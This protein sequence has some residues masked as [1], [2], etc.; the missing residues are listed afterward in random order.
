MAFQF[1]SITITNKCSIKD[2]TSSNTKHHGQFFLE[3]GLFVS[4]VWGGSSSNQ[5]HKSVSKISQ[6]SQDF[7]KIVA[8][9]VTNFT[10]HFIRQQKDVWAT[11]IGTG[12]V[13]RIP[14]PESDI[15]S[16]WKYLNWPEFKWNLTPWT[17]QVN[18]D[19]FPFIKNA[20]ICWTIKGNCLKMKANDHRF[21][22][23]S[24]CLVSN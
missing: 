22:C 6:I 18:H 23:L 5:F 20:L 9:F 17:G 1:F 16:A 8:A 4:T 10:K 11:R 19:L 14:W 21:I 3:K 24:I 2:I 13:S 7:S 15:K 12:Q